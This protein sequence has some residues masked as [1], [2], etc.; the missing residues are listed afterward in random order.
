MTSDLR[1]PVEPDGR[2]SRIRLSS[3]VAPRVR[4]YAVS[5]ASASA[6]DLAFRLDQA[7]VR[8][9]GMRPPRVSSPSSA[10]SRPQSP[11]LPGDQG[12]SA[13]PCV[14][15][16]PPRLADRFISTPRGALIT[17]WCFRRDFLQIPPRGGH[18]CLVV[19]VFSPGKDR[20]DSNPLMMNMPSARRNETLRLR[21]SRR[22]GGPRR[23]ERLRLRGKLGLPAYRSAVAAMAAVAAA[24][25]PSERSH[26]TA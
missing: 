13:S 26:A 22:R 21:P 3:V 6:G 19:A 15:G 7:S 8:E 25:A 10:P 20:R 2:I 12:T 1:P 4:G 17:G 9:D 18:A 16:S 14:A 23:N 5:Q 24:G 11:C